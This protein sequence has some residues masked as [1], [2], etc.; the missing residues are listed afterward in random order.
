MDAFIHIINSDTNPVLDVCHLCNDTFFR[1]SILEF[2][3][4]N[5]EYEKAVWLLENTDYAKNMVSERM[6]NHMNKSAGI[7]KDNLHHFWKAVDI[8][9]G[10]GHEV[11]PA[12]K[13]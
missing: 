1:F 7:R 3:V 12:I 4:R 5:R 2:A 11:N 6:L 9:R 13:R 8:V 10:L